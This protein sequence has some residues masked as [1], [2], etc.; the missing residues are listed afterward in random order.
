VLVRSGFRGALNKEPGSPRKAAR[1]SVIT[2]ILPS[3]NGSLMAGF[4]VAR[5]WLLKIEKLV[6]KLWLYPGVIVCADDFPIDRCA[7]KKQ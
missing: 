6:A 3:K 4:F 2:F 1:R 5:S 7:V